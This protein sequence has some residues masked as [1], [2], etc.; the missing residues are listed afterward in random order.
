MHSGQHTTGF[1]GW[2]LTDKADA[3]MLTFI[4]CLCG[5][6]AVAGLLLPAPDMPFVSDIPFGAAVAAF[7]AAL[8][9]VVLAWPLHFVLRRRPGYYARKDD[10]A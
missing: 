8:I 3:H 10:A 6:L 2:A 5:L 7:A 1:W 4:A 9:A